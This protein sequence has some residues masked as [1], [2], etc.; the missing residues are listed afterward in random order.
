MAG[1]EEFENDDD[2]MDGMKTAPL[3][4]PAFA[5]TASVRSK[6]LFIFA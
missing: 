4:E 1:D 3:S 2:G 5:A 6:Y